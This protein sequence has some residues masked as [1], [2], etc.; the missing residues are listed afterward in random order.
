MRVR[1]IVGLAFVLSPA[2]AP[3]A[4][5]GA[6][7]EAQRPIAS[8]RASASTQT[9]ADR[10]G[11][12]R[13]RANFRRPK[14]GEEDRSFCAA[15]CDRAAGESCVLVGV[16]AEKGAVDA[17]DFVEARKRYERAC[18][19]NVPAGCLHLGRLVANGQGGDADEA[20]AFALYARA[21]D[22]GDLFGCNNLGLLYGDGKGVAVDKAKGRALLGRACD[23]GEGRACVNLAI[24]I[25]AEAGSGAPRA[26]ELYG[27][28]CDLGEPTGC[29][30]AAIGDENGEAGTPNRAKVLALRVRGCELGH[31]D[32]CAKAALGHLDGL[33]TKRDEARATALYAIG[34][35]L[36]DEESCEAASAAYAFGIGV[37]KDEAHAEE[38][39]LRG[40][41]AKPGACFG[42]AI[43]LRDRGQH[44][45]EKFAFHAFSRL[46]RTKLLPTACVGAGV[47]AQ[48]GKGIEK[49]DAIARELY[50]LACQAKVPI[51]CLD[52]AS[53]ISDEDPK[54]AIQLWRDTC[55]AP[56][57]GG[58]MA[59]MRTYESGMSGVARDRRRAVAWFVRA[60]PM[61]DDDDRRTNEKR[62][63]KFETACAETDGAACRFAGF[64]RAYGVSGAASWERAIDR[65]ER[66]CSALKDTGSCVYLGVATLEGLGVARDGKRGLSLLEGACTS[67]DVEACVELARALVEGSGGS[68]DPKRAAKLLDAACGDGDARACGLR[69]FF[70]VRGDKPFVAD[71]ATR[72]AVET[73]CKEGEPWACAAAGLA[74]EKG[75]GG[76]VDVAGAKESYR[77]GCDEG[78]AVACVQ[79]AKLLEGP[80]KLAAGDA[81]PSWKTACDLGEGAACERV[82]E[83]FES[84]AKLRDEAKARDARADACRLGR[85]GSCPKK[86]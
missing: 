14:L 70:G 33:A 31:A 23:G 67:G 85:A 11:V 75:L 9:A 73:S 19:A 26:R 55:A 69:A 50:D 54:R 68:R 7:V 13:A 34:C 74:R 51:G 20:K 79:L 22:G 2:F 42:A 37:A 32:S 66:G 24:A 72:V 15:A 60:R 78:A 30:N 71:A 16:M 61:L 8:A 86:K 40:C 17:P 29:W 77:R 44:D 18:D 27:K 41:T 21:C 38:L 25:E 45:S 62:L 1:T 47:M 49:S 63:D 48:E 57:S 80:K 5:S 65:W 35:E 39:F 4:C 83:I 46:C 43:V 58:C 56:E 82:A 53:A 52:L 64:Y 28:A 10:C 12:A 84:D 76:G 36:R 81:L 59:L 6:P 3:L